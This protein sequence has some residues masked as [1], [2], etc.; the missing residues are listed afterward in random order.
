M[1]LL[2][3]QDNRRRKEAPVLASILLLAGCAGAAVEW[4]NGF[5][6]A[7]LWFVVFLVLSILILAIGSGVYQIDETG[8]ARTDPLGLIR[9]RMIPWDAFVY[10]GVLNVARRFSGDFGGKAIV[11]A[12]FVPKKEHLIGT[13]FKVGDKGAV[14]IAYDLEQYEKIL[15]IRDAAAKEIL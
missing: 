9:W 7:A 6:P 8:I 2:I 3:W 13:Y 5:V 12:T 11:C 1:K 4:K 15:K 10:I 14:K